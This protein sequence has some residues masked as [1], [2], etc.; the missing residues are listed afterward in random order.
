MLILPPQ[1]VVDRGKPFQPFTIPD[2][3]FRFR[4]GDLVFE[5][6]YGCLPQDPQY[7]TFSPRMPQRAGC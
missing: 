4:R 3:E 5:V 2:P 6:V 7:F 1:I